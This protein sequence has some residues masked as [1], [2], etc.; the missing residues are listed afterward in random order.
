MTASPARFAYRCL[1]LVI[2]NSHGWEILVDQTFTATWSGGSSAAELE[3]S[4]PAGERSPLPASHFGQGVLTLQ[5]GYLFETEELYSLWV[6]GPTNQPKDG[7]VPLCGVIETDWVPYTFTMN[8][9]FTRPGTVRFEKGEPYCHFFPI[10]RGLLSGFDPE[11]R[12]LREVPEK[13]EMFATW[14]ASRRDTVERLMKSEIEPTDEVWS[15]HYFKGRAP[16]GEVFAKEHQTRLVVKPFVDHTAAQVA[17]WAGSGRQHAEGDA[18]NGERLAAAPPRMPPPVRMVQAHFATADSAATT[19]AYPDPLLSAVID[20]K[21]DADEVLRRALVPFSRRLCDDREARSAYLWVRRNGGGEDLEVHVH[22]P[23]ALAAALRCWLDEAVGDRSLR[24]SQYQRSDAALGG[25]ELLA[26]PLYAS[27]ATL[28]LGRGCALVLAALGRDAERGGAAGARRTPL[29]QALVGGLAALRL[30]AGKRSSYLAFHRDSVLR[31][32]LAPGA[33]SGDLQQAVSF[34]E[35]RAEAASEVVERLRASILEEE[36]G[37]SGDL[38]AWRSSLNEL[39]AFVVQHCAE[40]VNL[41]DLPVA[42]PVFG[43][44]FRAF[45]GVA[46]QAGMARAD[47]AFLCHLLLRAFT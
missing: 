8:W 36:A 7:L 17:R 24:W 28:C 18:A 25:G 35:R 22:G 34:L 38:V 47:E 14:R 5:V 43:P 45:H 23:E 11:F 15:R 29:L 31:E 9:M 46:Q 42:D 41:A 26:D 1:P 19:V 21:R 6:M 33:G 32:T 13:A 3:V 12:D 30:Q 40:R 16:N 2:A 39:Y 20:C 4:F 37:G 27:L 10:P 44:L